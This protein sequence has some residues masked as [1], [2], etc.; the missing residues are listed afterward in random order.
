MH[1]YDN[2][3]T[4]ELSTQLEKVGLAQY[5]RRDAF[6]MRAILTLHTSP[7]VGKNILSALH[8]ASPEEL[9][10]TVMVARQIFKPNCDHEIVNE[11]GIAV[12]KRCK[13]FWHYHCINSPDKVCKNTTEDDGI[14]LRLVTGRKDSKTLKTQIPLEFHGGECFFCNKPPPTKKQFFNLKRPPA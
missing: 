10:A 1:K 4:S 3:S 7:S 13:K 14:T 8:K 11:N 9:E 6:V 12:C 2:L 5:A